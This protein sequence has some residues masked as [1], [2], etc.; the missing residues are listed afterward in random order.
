MVESLDNACIHT[1]TR[2]LATRLSDHAERRREEGKKRNEYKRDLEMEG[3]EEREN[4][5]D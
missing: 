1:H 2:T 5:G 4:E 3:E